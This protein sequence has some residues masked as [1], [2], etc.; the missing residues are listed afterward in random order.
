MREGGISKRLVSFAKLFFKNSMTAYG[1][2]CIVGCAFFGA[3]SGSAVA[4][5]AAIGGIMIP[6]MIRHRYKR[7]YAGSLASAAGYLGMLIPPSVPIV[8]Y[9]ITSG[10][11]IG[12]TFIAGVVPGLLAMV[13]QI[14]VNKIFLKKFTNTPEE[15]LAV[16]GI[17]EE[18]ASEQPHGKDLLKVLLEVIPGIL[19]PV[20][21]LGGIY[22]GI[23]TATEAA[24]VSIVYGTFVSV[25]LYKEISLKDIPRVAVESAKTAGK[26]L[27][28]VAF[29]SFFGR[30][31]TLL[32]IPSM[33]TTAV[34][35]ISSSPAAIM[36]IIISL[37]FVFGM[38][39]DMSVSII[40][41]V[42]IIQPI[43]LQLGLDPVHIAMI[44]VFALGIGL[45]TPPM[46]LN[47]FVGS[48]ISKVPMSKM[49][50]PIIPYVVASLLVL[51]LIVLVPQIS[52]LLPSLLGY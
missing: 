2:I 29:A 26:V 33:I 24:A 6:E 37:L 10:D 18:P 52:T 14:I 39:M 32:R 7:E 15:L 45:I 40:L 17:V 4:A 9:C 38:V 27:V 23:F 20:I 21:I 48:Q 47:L 16:E 34:L 25:V 51:L 43:M 31:L 19:M 11:S 28:I 13:A 35:G 12:E 42:P 41:L 50:R 5:V 49:V 1:T 8:L 22:A 46:A 36:L 44:I 3:I 30:L